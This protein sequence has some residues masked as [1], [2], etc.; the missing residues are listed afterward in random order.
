MRKHT[1]FGLEVQNH[2]NLFPVDRELQV[3]SGLWTL[4][5]FLLSTWV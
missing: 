4:Y 2:E 3:S 1:N 5:L